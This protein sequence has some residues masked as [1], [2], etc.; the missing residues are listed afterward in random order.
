VKSSSALFMSFHHEKNVKLPAKKLL[1][2]LRQSQVEIYRRM[3]ALMDYGMEL[4]LFK[5]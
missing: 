3:R 5:L 1:T 2:G 4:A